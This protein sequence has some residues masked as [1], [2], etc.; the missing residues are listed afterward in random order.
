[1]DIAERF[2]ELRKKYIESQF[3]N[4]NAEQLEAA[5]SIKGAALVLAGAGSGKTTVIVNRI[6]NLLRFG[7]AYESEV[8]WPDATQED[9]EELGRIIKSGGKPSDDLAYKLK[10]G[11]IRPWNILAITFTNK[12]ASQL[13]ERIVSAVGEDGNDVFASTFHSACVR[14][15]RRDAERLGWPQNFTIYDTDDS[16][17]V[18]KDICKELGINSDF[19]PVR[20]LASRFSVIRD[21]MMTEEEYRSSH[22]SEPSTDTVLRVYSQYRKK[23]KE[24]GAFDFD[25]LIYYTVRLLED[26]PDVRDYYHNRFKFIMVDEYQDTSHAQYRLVKLLANEDNN[27]FAVGDDDQSIY[28]FRGANIENILR[29]EKDFAPAK[30]IR[31]E[32]NYRSTGNILSCANSV[33]RKN[34]SRKGKEL[35]TEKEDGEKVEIRLVDDETSE[36]AFVAQ[37][38]MK[39]RKKGVPFSAHAVLYRTNAQ[40]N[41]FETYFMRTG[42]PYKIVGALRFFDRAEIKDVMSYMAIVSQPSDDLRLKRIINRPSRKIGNATVESIEQ[43]ALALGT[44]MM[45]VMANAAEY[46]S[47]SRALPAIKRFMEMYGKLCDAY[48][49]DTL[50]GFTEKLL[51][52][53]G[54]RDMLMEPGS[55]NESRLENVNEFLSTVRN[56]EKEHPEGDLAAFLEELALYSNMDDYDEN[57]DRVSLMTVHSA[58]GLE[59][60]YVYLAGMEEGIFPSDRN[61]GERDIEEE[62]RL[63][64]VGMTRAREELHMTHASVRMLYGY[65]RRNRR[66]RFLDEADRR[67]VT[68]I[69]EQ[70]KSYLDSDYGR[71]NAFGN[72]SNEQSHR[73]NF[74]R[75]P[76]QSGRIQQ[77]RQRPQTGAGE[78]KSHIS[79]V[80]LRNASSDKVS[81]APGD[82]V[83]H[84]MFGKGTVTSVT[85]VGNDSLVEISFEKFG[86]KKTMANYAPMKKITEGK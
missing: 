69:G 85:P 24:A 42:V 77:S 38:V 60:D 22:L 67:Y 12:A 28:S 64:Y 82:L 73:D 27:V 32:Q 52:I 23:L 11:N 46:P 71:A 37:E 70:R 74:R 86:R 78:L 50:G 10:T 20:M 84:R 59:F 29:F 56:Y 33:I 25:D 54:Y 5:M 31:L 7:D 39:H 66:S 49:E 55:E 17:R 47:L 44:S 30:V 68:E 16:E 43:I 35:W 61:T 53:T 51:D 26:N 3:G 13:K 76:F 36:A 40:S 65:T 57:D 79:T 63:A 81:Y 80:P 6:M 1:M 9:I 21:Y 58:K 83:E 45:E 19:Y 8:I 2:V 4:L 34:V 72:F 41:A 48:A 62:R 14:F 15:L 75:D 18:I